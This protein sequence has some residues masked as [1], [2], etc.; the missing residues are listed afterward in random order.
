MLFLPCVFV[1]VDGDAMLVSMISRTV[2]HHFHFHRP[3]K[4]IVFS[5]DG[6]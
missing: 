1:V 4:A 6:K 3:V 5:P 2:L